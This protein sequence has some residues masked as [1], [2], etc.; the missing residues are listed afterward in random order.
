MPNRDGRKVA[1]VTGASRGIGA[2]IAKALAQ[3]GYLIGV[4]YNTD[5][6][7]VLQVV[8]QI[9]DASEGVATPAIPLQGDISNPES[10]G[11]ML[12]NL[13][14]V[15]GGGVDILVNNAGV[16]A[17]GLVVRMSDKEWSYV[18]GINLTG[19]FRLS[20]AVLRGMIHNKWGRII[21]ITSI[22]GIDGNAGQVNYSASKAGIIGLTKALAKEVGSRNITVNAVAPGLIE[23]AMTTIVTEA[24]W[25]EAVKRQSI[26]RR[27]QPGDVAPI[28]AFLASDDA[29]FITGLVLRVDG[30][31]MV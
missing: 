27:G 14:H 28:V 11:P 29:S 21:N 22:A 10:I 30:G 1:L 9:E 16:T 5:E 2:A 23:T 20:K 25:D 18:I 19:T 24:Q 7:G 6:E 8:R 3:Q 12:E 17:D 26:G 31:L 4:N 15:F 13:Q